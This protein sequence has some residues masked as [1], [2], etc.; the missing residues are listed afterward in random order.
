VVDW[1]HAPSKHA[2]EQLAQGDESVKALRLGEIFY[3][4][5][6]VAAGASFATSHGAEQEDTTHTQV[7][8]L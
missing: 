4:Q 3:E 7:T 1:V 6:H 8:D 2:F 5:I